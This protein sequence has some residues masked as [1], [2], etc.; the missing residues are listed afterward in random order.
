MYSHTLDL[1]NY[2]LSSRV[3]RLSCICSL[4]LVTA[5]AE[6]RLAVHGIKEVVRSSEPELAEEPK[7]TSRSELEKVNVLGH[8]KVGRPY[9]INGLWYYPKVDPNYNEVGIA[10]WYGEQFHGKLTANGAIYDMNALTAAHKTL[11]MPSKVNLTSQASTSNSGSFV[12]HTWHVRTTPS[13][14]DSFTQYL[15]FLRK[16]KFRKG[17]KSIDERSQKNT[18]GRFVSEATRYE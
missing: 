13:V 10:S 9:E 1:T 11:P 7:D 2:V 14:S 16:H 17:M 5:C 4:L 8:Y 15:C 18:N 12:L 3:F 6:T